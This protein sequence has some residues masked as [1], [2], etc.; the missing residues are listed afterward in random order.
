MALNSSVTILGTNATVASAGTSVLAAVAVPDNCSTIVFYNE[1]ASNTIIFIQGLAAGAGGALAAATSVHIPPQTSFTFAI[2]T[3]AQR[4]N[5]QTNSR[6]L[7]DAVGGAA[8][9]RITYIMSLSG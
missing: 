3:Q 5:W 9:V 7:Y 1:N 2:G 6:L 4:V 8:I